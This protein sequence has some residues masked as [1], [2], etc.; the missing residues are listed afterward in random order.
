MNNIKKL[1]ILRI[2]FISS[3][4]EFVCKFEKK[5]DYNE[6]YVAYANEYE[7]TVDT[8]SLEQNASNFG[9]DENSYKI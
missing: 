8:D 3:S 2:N 6:Y 7:G 5:Y 9:H 1:K 4:V